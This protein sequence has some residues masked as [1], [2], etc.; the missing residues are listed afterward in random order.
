MHQDAR[1][2]LNEAR[3]VYRISGLETD[4]MVVKGGD[5][6]FFPWLGTREMLTMFLAAKCAGIPCEKRRLSLVYKCSKEILLSHLKRLRNGCFSSQQLL[7]Y[8]PEKWVEKYDEFV[9]E[10]LLDKVN[11]ER[12]LSFEL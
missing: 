7:E 4:S 9:P 10:E 3:E 6:H 12:L 2:R 8:L 11:A 1:V 5:I